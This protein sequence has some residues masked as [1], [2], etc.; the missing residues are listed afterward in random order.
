MHDPS[1]PFD[2]DFTNF[3]PLPTVTPAQATR[4]TAAVEVGSS[5]LK[6][7]GF[8][9]TIPRRNTNP[10]VTS[11]KPLILIIDDDATVREVLAIYLEVDGYETRSAGNRDEIMRE[12]KRPPLPD[13][14][15]CDVVMPDV[16]G[17]DLLNKFRQS[18]ALKNIPV[19]ML[20]G[21][22]EKKDIMKGLSL[23]AVGYITKPAKLG[24]VEAAMRQ[25]LR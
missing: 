13:L 10:P 19:V 24:V 18:N 15:L 2:L 17:F 11:R 6:A 5:Q 3:E 12:L 7:T 21:R 4:F 9:V 25:L 14:I 22:S 8:F 1:D 20:T 23:G 16:D